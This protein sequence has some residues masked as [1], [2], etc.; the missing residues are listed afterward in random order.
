[1]PT[2]QWGLI[3][4][5][6]KSEGAVKPMLWWRYRDD[7]FDIW[8]HGLPKLL[9][10]TDYINPLYPTIKFELVHSE[11][12]LPQCLGSHFAPSGRVYQDRYLC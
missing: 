2:W 9:E 3:N 11:H 1:M 4:E 12:T 5:K 10:F 8:P 7:V 6:A